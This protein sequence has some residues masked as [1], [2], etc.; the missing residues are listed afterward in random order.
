MIKKKSYIFSMA[1]FFIIFSIVVSFSI[2]YYMCCKKAEEEVTFNSS[3]SYSDFIPFNDTTAN[4]FAINNYLFDRTKNICPIVVIGAG[5]AGYAAALYAARSGNGVIVFKGESPGGQLA[6][7][8]S[9]EN[10]PGVLSIKDLKILFFDGPTIMENAEKQALLFGAKFIEETAVSIDTSI[11]PYKVTGDNGTVINALTIVLATGA[12]PNTLN[13]PGE[14]KY[15]GKGVTTCA[16][17]DAALHKD[18][19]VIIVGGG[20][21]ACEEAIQLI[22]YASEIIMLIR[23]NKMRASKIMQDRVKSENK[24][25][26]I[27]NSSIISIE[28]DDE[29]VTNV[30]YSVDNQEK[31]M[32]V[33]GVFIAIGHTPNINLVKNSIE[34]TDQKLIKCKAN[35][36]ETSIKGFFAA[37]DVENMYRQA[38]VAAGNGIKAALDACSFLYSNGFKYSFLEEYRES[39]FSFEESIKLLDI[40]KSEE[41]K[42][43][44]FSNQIEKNQTKSL[45]SESNK[46]VPFKEIIDIK[47]EKELN[48]YLKKYKKVAIDFYGKW[49]P[50]CKELKKIIHE[51]LT[52][53]SVVFPILSVDIDLLGKIAQSAKIVTL[54]TLIVYENGKELKRFTGYRNQK[55]FSSFLNN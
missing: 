45:L 50:P 52:K 37:G 49:C 20:D 53:N 16:I 40:S 48:F 29:K 26:I 51:Y 42:S 3:N 25:K 17:C 19:R 39:F 4:P 18:K 22:P 46:L 8:G 15:W 47:N 27:Y 13:C 35:T 33:S 43:D 28:G 7:T 23:S 41:E 30:I 2:Y 38:G 9:V 54:P 34:L 10:W 21:S 6:K 24:I 5:C 32:E 44:L 55:E 11:W 36:Q 12:T 1:L 31:A 14:K